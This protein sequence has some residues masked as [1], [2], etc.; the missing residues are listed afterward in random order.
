MKNIKTFVTYTPSYRCPWMRPHLIFED[1]STTSCASQGRSPQNTKKYTLNPK[2]KG[3]AHI[4]QHLH[5]ETV[6][7]Q[8]GGFQNKC[9]I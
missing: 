2:N 7:A 5:P 6:L 3:A 1:P 8:K 4:L 9:N